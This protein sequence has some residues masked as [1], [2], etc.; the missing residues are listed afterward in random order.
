MYTVITLARLF[1]IVS[2]SVKPE[3]SSA[4]LNLPA[5]SAKQDQ[6]LK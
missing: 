4:S 2:V 6:Q 5:E 3:H 1:K